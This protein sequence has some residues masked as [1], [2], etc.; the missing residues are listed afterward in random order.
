MSW[1]EYKVPSWAE[2]APLA[3]QFVVGGP[4]SWTYIFRGQADSEWQLQPTLTRLA[5]KLDLKADQAVEVEKEL[6]SEFKGQANLHL[7]PN[8]FQRHMDDFWWQT[9]M[10]H[11]HVPSRLLDWTA[12]IFVAAYH[13]VAQQWDKAG[14]VW[15]FHAKSFGEGMKKTFEGYNVD[16]TLAFKLAEFNKPDAPDELYLFTRHQKT[17]RMIAQQS[18][19]TACKQIL[20]DH[21]EIIEN[22]ITRREGETLLLKIIIKPDLKPEFLRQLRA[23]NITANALFPGVD[24]LGLSLEELARMQAHHLKS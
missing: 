20:A 3:S 4:T 18:L 8:A 23:A 14:A 19:F 10:R 5:R 22:A 21:G 15:V 16:H 7:S 11:H 12:S 13:A 9:L 24:G 6:L 17:D 2:F 1:P